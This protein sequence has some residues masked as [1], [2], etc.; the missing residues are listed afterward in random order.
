M[1]TIQLANTDTRLRSG[2]TGR[3]ARWL[4]AALV[5]GLSLSACA[6]EDAGGEDEAREV[7]AQGEV[8][9]AERETRLRFPL[10]PGLRRDAGV[11]PTPTTPTPTA[12]TP[13][14]PTPQ[15][16]SCRG[17]KMQSTPFGCSFAWGTNDPGDKLAS[18]PELRFVSK[19]VGWEVQKDGSL[20][21]CDGCGW[22]RNQVAKTDKVPVYY[23]YFI[24]F[25]G[26]ANG[27]MD[28]NQNPNGPNLTTDGANLIRKNRAKI[29]DL[30]A[31]YARKSREV[32]PDKPIVWLLEGDH[33]QY[34]GESQKNR[35][36]YAELG[37]LTA[38][39]ACAIKANMPN[40]LV[41]I[42]HSTWNPDQVTNDFWRA[43]SVASYDLVWTTG[44]ANNNGFFEQKAS[45]SSYNAKT[46]TYRYIRQLTGRNILVDTSFGL[47]AMGDSWSTADVNTLNAR[48]ADGVIAANVVSPAG[49]FQQKIRSLAPQLTRVCK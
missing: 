15:A 7:S 47:S 12:P 35:L 28:G 31:Q 2:R 49:A 20:S 41:A 46:A 6:S 48:I 3:G 17:A 36:S 25:F 1:Q 4:G 21:S 26:H 8:E 13:S 34:A 32:Y 19:W 29:V 22:L 27:F 5:A 39:I 11:A 23:A 45:P 24:G 14:T 10:F 38:D 18:L 33:V 30:Y 37:Q 43:M 16:G 42:N 40:A 44:V 9:T